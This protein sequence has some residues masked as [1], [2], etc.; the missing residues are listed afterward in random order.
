MYIRLVICN[1]EL[2]YLSLHCLQ[3]FLQV[4][5]GFLILLLLLQQAALFSLQLADLAAQIQLLARLFLSQLLHVMLK[6]PK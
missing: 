3:L 5:T 1:G 2:L 6:L 4:T